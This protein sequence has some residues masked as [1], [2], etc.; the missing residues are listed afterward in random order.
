MRRQPSQLA[1]HHRHESRG[2][3]GIPVPQLREQLSYFVRRQHDLSVGT[4]Q[5]GSDPLFYNQGPDAN[6][7]DARRTRS[8]RKTMT[9]T[10][11]ARAAMER[12]AQAI[13]TAAARLGES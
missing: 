2:R 3:I 13:L 12:E 4:P 7:L 6:S 8:V 5:P 1:I 9:T 11:V 10:E